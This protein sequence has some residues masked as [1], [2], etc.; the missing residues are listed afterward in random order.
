MIEESDIDK[1]FEPFYTKKIDL[2]Q[3]SQLAVKQSETRFKARIRST[4]KKLY[5]VLSLLYKLRLL[6]QDIHFLDDPFNKDKLTEKMDSLVREWFKL[7]TLAQCIY[8]EYPKSLENVFY[9]P[10]RNWI[11]VNVIQSQNITQNIYLKCVSVVQEQDI[12]TPTVT[13]SDTENN[14]VLQRDVDY[15]Y[16][17]LEPTNDSNNANDSNDSNNAN[18]IT[19]TT[20][21]VFFPVGFTFLPQDEIYFTYCA[22]FFYRAPEQAHV[23]QKYSIIEDALFA[24][25]MLSIKNKTVSIENI[26]NA[27]HQTEQLLQKIK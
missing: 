23:G 14:F 18:E 6:F 22:H 15:D 21:C 27:Y 7:G 13:F 4:E 25:W 2:I 17:I 1:I 3:K 24:N 9:S 26:E 5:I 19:E 10:Q 12:N 11:D 16:L 20:P 8:N